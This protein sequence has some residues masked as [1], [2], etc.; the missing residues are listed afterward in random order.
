MTNEMIF[1]MRCLWS[2]TRFLFSP[3]QRAP[4]QAN[5]SIV[6]V[7]SKFHLF[8]DWI[9]SKIDGCAAASGDERV[10][11]ARRLLFIPVT[12]RRQPSTPALAHHGITAMK[13]LHT[14]TYGERDDT[15]LEH[16]VDEHWDEGKDLLKHLPKKEGHG[17]TFFPELK[18]AIFFCGHLVTDL[19]SI[20]GA[21][22]AANLYGGV[23]ARASEINTETEFALEHWGLPLPPPVEDLLKEKPDRSVCLVD[24]QQQ[25][26]LNK[27]IPMGNIVGVIDH[28]ALQS[29][30]IV[31]EKPIFVDIRPWGCM[32][33]I[34]AHNYATMGVFL[35]KN[36]TGLLLSAILSDT[37]NLRS[38]TT[39]AWDERI[40]SMLVQYVGV[41]DVNELA[42]KQ[43][44]A[45]SH[46]LS[47]MTPYALVNGDMKQFKFTNDAVGKTYTVAYSVVET[48]DA[49]A[50]L[51]RTH[52]ILPELRGGEG[53]RPADAPIDAVF[54][55]VVDIVNLDSTLLVCGRIEGPRGGGVRGKT[56]GRRQ[57]A[58]DAGFGVEEERFRPGA[59][60]GGAGG[61]DPGRG[62]RE[63]SRAEG[64]EAIEVHGGR[65]AGRRGGGLQRGAER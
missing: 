11:S 35:P 12:L 38:P 59:H 61:L 52:E 29:N 45:K 41:E 37:L 65:R 4:A 18:D 36:I 27:A 16:A 47:P 19:D 44:R 64:P 40:V 13:H 25:S 49:A 5:S 6:N 7:N 51:A 54:L 10:S 60:Q 26:Q 1:V 56:R 2:T 20:A 8:H 30:T 34:I 57:R 21:I 43:F 31:T 23:P 53:Q 9:S 22:G 63:R 32:S 42:A 39:T 33:S 50:S 58:P 48:T 46:A 62:R 55:A 15:P 14:K 24:F 28:H 17:D 3:F